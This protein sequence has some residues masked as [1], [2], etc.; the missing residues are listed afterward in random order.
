MLFE[1][2]GMLVD[3]PT[4]NPIIKM[5]AGNNIFDGGDRSFIFSETKSYNQYVGKRVMAT[6]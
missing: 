6:R 5:T 4:N 3:P 2:T 1:C